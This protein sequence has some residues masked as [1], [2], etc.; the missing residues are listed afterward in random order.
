M[1]S[2]APKFRVRSIADVALWLAIVIAPLA[3]GSSS[4][5]MLPVLAT[6]ATVAYA[7]SV[8]GSRHRTRRFDLFGLP[9]ALL[10]LAVFTTVQAVPV[11]AGLLAW[12]S[13]R[14]HELRAFTDTASGWV[15]ISYEPGATFRSAAE[16]CVYAL[17][18]LVAYRQTQTRRSFLPIAAAV[19]VAGVASGAVALLHR[20][21]GA[22]RMLGVLEAARSPATLQT[23]FVN[24]NHAAGFMSLACLCALG[25]AA[26][27]RERH[28]AAGFGL[29]AAIC[30][31]TAVMSFSRGGVLALVAGLVA[32]GALAAVQRRR[33]GDDFDDD[34]L[35]IRQGVL[36]A[37][38]LVVSVGAAM[39]SKD[40]VLRALS[41]G[42]SSDPL[43]I[44]TKIA[45]MKDAWPLMLDHPWLGIG[46]G[47]YET[48]YPAYKTSVYQLTFTR[49][50][51]IF[52]QL[53]ADW[54]VVAGG[55]AAVG[56]LA[57][58]IGRTVRARTLTTIGALVGVL[59]LALQNLVD[60]SLEVPGVAISAAAILGG[61]AV[62]TVKRIRLPIRGGALVAVTVVA[63][64]LL[65]AGLALGAFRLPNLQF[66]LDR[67]RA[68][69]AEAEK[70]PNSAGRTIEW[71]EEAAA[72]HPANPMFAAGM[73]YLIEVAHPS[74]FRRAIRW[75][76]RTLF[77]APTYADG[78][79][80]SGRLLVRLGH[81][82]QGFD[83]MRTGWSMVDPVRREGLIAEVVRLARRPEEILTAIPRSDEVMDIPSAR[84]VATAAW[85]LRKMGKPVW[86]RQLLDTLGPVD[87]IEPAALL[88]VAAAA[89]AVK[90]STIAIAAAERRI[91]ITPDDPAPRRV[92]LQALRLTGDD[93]RIEALIDEVLERR[94]QDPGPFLRVRLAEA[95]RRGELDRARETLARWQR[96]AVPTRE[97]Q[98]ELA[99]VEADIEQKAGNVASAV[100]ALGRA[101]DLKPGAAGLRCRRASLLTK[102]G[103]RASARR[104][105]EWVLRRDPDHPQARAQ[106]RKIG[107]QEG[108]QRLPSAS[109]SPPE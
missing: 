30:A 22:E 70:A 76:N 84:H 106:L 8:L 61:T 107:P 36:L 97:N 19:A 35:R 41:E 48:V 52:A 90:A 81:R 5:W 16:L 9:V 26:G 3:G 105:L 65:L 44:S 34:S 21:L 37:G 78:H 31:L 60:F 104:D 92:L 7:A 67:L 58:M 6:L 38:V 62:G 93:A 27:A 108:G 1:E 55:L 29:V 74:D 45:A 14:A 24:P 28:H 25:I 12:L 50:E 17:I 56:I 13:P 91:R 85:K 20:A 51:N 15:P 49:P 42:T 82:P 23:T 57:C 46:R 101:I 98:A 68:G 96:T 99:R 4:I 83:A 32:F 103:R 80:A 100:R 10:L 53:A 2:T 69:L 75:T 39:W 88:D 79:L 73:A 11:P 18:A 102:L 47:A 40:E 43:A 77:L 89:V 94:V 95:L 71:L 72:D 54:G 33:D 109:P 59:A 64:I 86:G 63:P 66:D 87:A